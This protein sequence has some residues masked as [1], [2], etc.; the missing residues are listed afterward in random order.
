MKHYA[1]L[2]ALCLTL[3]GC[4]TPPQIEYR[5]VPVPVPVPCAAP[6]PPEPEYPKVE[7]SDDVYTAASKRRAGEKL[8]D[9]YI[10]KLK[11]SRFGCEEGTK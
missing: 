7:P 2:C 6:L 9:A 5:T 4:A 10:I 1:A 11:A 3:A 8:R